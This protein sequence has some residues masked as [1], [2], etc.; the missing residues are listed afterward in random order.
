MERIARR[1]PALDH[2]VQQSP[3]FGQRGWSAC[4]TGAIAGGEPCLLG[5][6]VRC[7]VQFG[8]RGDGACCALRAT[9]ELPLLTIKVGQG[10]KQGTQHA[11]VSAL[12]DVQGFFQLFPGLLRLAA[13]ALQHAEVAQ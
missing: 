4:L 3:C 10:V 11:V 7:P 9:L 12:G 8:V 13:L 1:R 5:L 2:V 6:P